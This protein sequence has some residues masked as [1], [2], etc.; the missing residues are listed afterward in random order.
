MGVTVSRYFFLQKNLT[1]FLF[2]ASESDDLLPLLAVV[3]SPLP[4]FH[5]P[6]RLSSVLS[7]FSHQKLIIVGCHPLEGSPPPSDATEANRRV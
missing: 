3:S 2:I 5:V 6:R 7:K 1:T 4:F